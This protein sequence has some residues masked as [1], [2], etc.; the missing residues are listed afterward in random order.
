MVLKTTLM[1]AMCVILGV[2]PGCGKKYDIR[3]VDP[4][5]PG[6]VRSLGPESQDV[7]G[8]SDTML[9]SILDSPVV[10]N[11]GHPPTIVMLPMEN[12]TRY[13]FNQEVFTSKL[14]SALNQKA[15]GQMYFVARDTWDDVIKERDMKREGTVDYDPER[16]VQAPAGADFFLKG[17]ADGLG[18]VSKKGQSDYIVYTFKLIDTETMVELWEDVYEVKKEGRDDVVYR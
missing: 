7:I 11:L 16:R 14:K 10:R 13:A 18:N 9:R 12:N 8:V 4:T 1:A 15:T 2:L 17:R 3:D 6:E 5:R